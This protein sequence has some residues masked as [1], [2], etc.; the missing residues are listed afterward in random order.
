MDTDIEILVGYGK[1]N[2]SIEYRSY[3]AQ[4][5]LP[6]WDRTNAATSGRKVRGSD[7]RFLLGHIPT[8]GDFVNS[9]VGHKPGTIIM[10]SSQW[11]RDGIGYADGVIFV[12]LREDAASWRITANL[13]L[14]HENA[15]GGEATVFEGRGDILSFADLATF[16]IVPGYAHTFEENFMSP[17]EVDMC[18]GLQQ[19]EPE[20]NARPNLVQV[21]KIDGTTQVKEVAEAPRRRLIIRR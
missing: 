9:R 15:H 21:K 10:L 5:V 7:N 13:P 20:R 11:R 4:K 12:R 17:E 2:F 14:S 16:G 8:H 19:V 6:K 1:A 3:M 18:F